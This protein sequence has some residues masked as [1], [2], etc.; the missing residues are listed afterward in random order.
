MPT[1]GKKEQKYDVYEDYAVGYVNDNTL[2]YIDLDDLERVSSFNW[3]KDKEGYLYTYI[4][5]KQVRLTQFIMNCADVVYYKNGSN[6]KN[7]N[8]KSNLTLTRPIAVKI[9]SNNT[10]GVVGVSYD[11]KRQLWVAYIR[12]DG[13]QKTLGRFID[14][15]DAIQARKNAELSL[16]GE[17]NE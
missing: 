8:R 3:Y 9:P 17:N 14:K 13:K 5:T 1:K 15:Q 11:K 2:F 6:S 10:S 16:R 7:D 12:H 4:N